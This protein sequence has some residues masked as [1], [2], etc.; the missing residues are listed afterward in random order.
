MT[1]ELLTYL[2]CVSMQWA[3]LCKNFEKSYSLTFVKLVVCHAQ[4]KLVLVGGCEEMLSRYFFSSV[5]LR[6]G[7]AYSDAWES[8]ISSSVFQRNTKLIEAVG[9]ETK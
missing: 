5:L 6:R 3:S 9:N 8:F 2:S 7:L 4:T 1:E